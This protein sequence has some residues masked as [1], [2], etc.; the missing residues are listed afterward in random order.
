MRREDQ[1]GQ[2]R[3]GQ[4]KSTRLTLRCLHSLLVS[5]AGDGAVGEEECGF[6]VGGGGGGGGGGEAKAAG[7]KS[8]DEVEVVW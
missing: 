2:V 7:T 1:T 5:I 6:K 4:V 3:R 8:A